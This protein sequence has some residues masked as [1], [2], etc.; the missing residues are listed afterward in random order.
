MNSCGD[1]RTGLP[2]LIVRTRQDG[3][4]KM[5]DLAGGKDG[6]AEILIRDRY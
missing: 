5:S 2:A 6:H 3:S 1:R 4:A